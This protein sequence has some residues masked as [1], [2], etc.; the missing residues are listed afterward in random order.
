MISD[1]EYDRLFDE[2][3]ELEKRY[4]DLADP[5]SPTKRVGSD[6]SNEFPD[7]EHRIP[8]LSLD[9]VYRM[10]ELK[11]WTEKR[12]VEV[13]RELDFVLEEKYDGA[14]IV[15]YYRQGELEAAVTRGNGRVGN[16][17]T[18]NIR[19]IG[20]I[21]LKVD[22][23]LDFSV[24]GEIYLTRSDF[25][26]LRDR[27][28]REY[29]NPRNLAAGTLRSLNSAAVARV[30]LKLAVYEGNFA[31]AVVS[32]HLD[33][34]A[35]LAELGFFIDRDIC[36]FSRR[37]PLRLPSGKSLPG[38][39][40]FPMDRLSAVIE[41]KRKRRD[42]LDYEI[43]GLVLK[44]N[45]LAAR[46]EIGQT[47]HHPKWAVAYKFEAPA[48]ETVID[49]IEIQVG[50]NG[51]VTPVAVLQP[52]RIAGSVVSRATLHNQ[53]YIDL[54]ELN[55]GDRVEIS[56]RGD[57]IPAVEKVVEKDRGRKGT[58][59]MPADCP[60]CGAPLVREGAHLFCPDP[61]CPE[62]K[63]RQIIHFCRRDCM[64][65][66]TLGEKTLRFL[67]QRGLVRDIPDLYRFEYRELLGLEG[68]QEKKVE[69]IIRSV[70]ESKKQPFHRVLLALG[71]ENL[72]RRVVELLIAHGYDQVD[73]IIRAAREQ[74]I[75]GFSA[76][77]GIGEHTARLI[78][79]QFSDP[80]QLR[81]IARLKESGLRFSEDTGLSSSDRLIFRDQRW[82]ITGSFAHFQPREKAA[83]VIRR[84][85]GRVLNTVSSRTT[86]VLA[87]RDPGSKYLRARELGIRI[88]K[89]PRFVKMI[90]EGKG[91][92]DQSD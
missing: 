74:D 92:A 10:D 20:E 26:T 39:R 2:L 31:P 13:N 6:L 63:I 42:G 14:S 30:P 82:V 62:R 71:F 64:D 61:D 51:R 48:A 29:A 24:R 11:E 34:L 66:E 21:P 16:V 50:R 81:R 88:V 91:D 19:T 72:G 28:S 85:G 43:D 18:E 86:H 77:E 67:F 1:R 87:G 84:H 55:I 8:V 37:P 7:F 54:L 53:D 25:L 32:T 59:R 73:K 90:R 79:K 60:F 5:N 46:P 45:D 36:L 58:Y 38:L 41:E 22:V 76:I 83:E 52:V 9:K 68:F 70:G 17:V 35:R 44:V 65:I 12:G 33:S 75:E 89:E 69:N 47:S 78:V 56:K 15:L 3:R 27:M 4:P 23:P 57:I 80:I 49:S 40:V